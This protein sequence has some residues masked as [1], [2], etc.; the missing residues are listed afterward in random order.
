MKHIYGPVPSWRLGRSLGIDLVSGEKS[1]PFDCIY[2]QL[3]KTIRHIIKRQV[4]VPTAELVKELETLPRMGIDYITFSGTGEPTLALNLGEVIDQIKGRFSKPVAVL[5]NSSLLHDPQVRREL[6]RAD[7]IIAKLDAP[8][9]KIF[10][11]INQPT[12]GIT[13][14]MILEGIRRFIEEY[15]GKLA[16]QIMFVPQNK[17]HA[18]DL[19]NLAKQ[20]N[21]VEVEINTPL[22]PCPI[23]PL[24]PKELSKIKE[25]FKPLKAYSAYDVVRPETKSMDEVETRRRRPEAR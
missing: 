9:E 3:G 19:A 11:I 14:Y 22:R 20:I 13:F 4:F 12:N 2:C 23:K 25:L 17:D 1:C 10:R 15:P 24:S 16:L 18:A 6:G 8:N 21:P 5:T 7:R